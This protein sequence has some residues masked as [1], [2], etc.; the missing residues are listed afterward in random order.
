MSQTWIPLQNFQTWSTV[1]NHVRPQAVSDKGSGVGSPQGYFSGQ[2]HLLEAHCLCDC[3]TYPWIAVGGLTRRLHPAGFRQSHREDLAG[4]QAKLAQAAP[5]S[6]RAS[7]PQ[8]QHKSTTG[9]QAAAFCPKLLFHA[10]WGRKQPHSTGSVQH[11]RPF[12]DWELWGGKAKWK[13][14]DSRT[15]TLKHM[16]I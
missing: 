12:A 8:P 15:I 9:T 4:T 7:S 6:Q 10:S 2:L 14:W 3:Y 16:E 11:L 1:L 13:L 5:T